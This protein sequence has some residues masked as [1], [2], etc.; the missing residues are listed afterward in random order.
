LN[1][2]RNYA[3]T[4]RYWTAFSLPVPGTLL[5]GDAELV[6]VAGSET[7]GEETTFDDYEIEDLQLTYCGIGVPELPG[8]AE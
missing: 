6:L 1:L 3:S 8:D 5:E 7:S 2:R 4:D